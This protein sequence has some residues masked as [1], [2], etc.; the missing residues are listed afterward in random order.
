MGMSV[1]MNVKNDGSFEPLETKVQTKTTD[2]YMNLVTP[3]GE[4]APDCAFTIEPQFAPTGA[5]SRTREMKCHANE[6]GVAVATMGLLEPYI[7]KV[8]PTGKADEYM[9]QSFVFQTDRREVTIVV[10]RSIFGTI[11]EDN[12]ALVIDTSGSMQVY[13]DDVKIALNS[14]ITEQLFQSQKQFNVATYTNP[15]PAQLN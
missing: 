8:K 2:V 4:P 13:L 11:G 5:M 1:E 12:V 10:A 6:S 3:D 9:T 14:V 7:F 15:T